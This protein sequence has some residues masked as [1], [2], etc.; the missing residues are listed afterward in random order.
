MAGHLPSAAAS[1]PN[2]KGANPWHKFGTFGTFDSN[3]KKYSLYDGS[4]PALMP[5]SQKSFYGHHFAI[6]KD[7][8][9][10]LVCLLPLK[11]GSRCYLQA[12]YIALK[13]IATNG[14]FSN[15]F[16]HV[17]AAHPEFILPLHLESNNMDVYS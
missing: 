4:F 10:D 3:T 7:S 9:N 15:A 8:P 5:S 14:N 17:L 16:K 6:S 11:S 12:G 13:N 2:Y 1:L